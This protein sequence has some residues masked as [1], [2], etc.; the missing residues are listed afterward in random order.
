MRSHAN[1]VYRY[2]YRLCGRREMADDLVQ[3][4]FCEAWKSI[5]SLRDPARGKAWLMQILRHRYAH[6]VRDQSRR[7]KATSDY[8][9]VEQASDLRASTDILTRLSDQETLQ[10]SLSA[11]DDRYK[12]PFLMVFQEGLTCQQ[13]ADTLELPLGTVLSRIHRARQSLRAFIRRCRLHPQSARNEDS[14]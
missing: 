3:E 14:R 10:E 7:I 1:D 5:G 2:A 8:E 13:T 9:Q 4:T 11:L 12:E 6:A